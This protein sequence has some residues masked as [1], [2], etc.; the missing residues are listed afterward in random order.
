MDPDKI[1]DTM[2][3]ETQKAVEHTRQEFANIHTG[4]ASPAMV[5]NV[6]VEAY[7]SS[8]QLKAVA[9]I[10]TPDSRTISVTPFDRGTLNDVVKGIQVAN[11]G[12]NPVVMGDKVHVPLPELTKERREQL[13]K[14]CSG[15][16]EQGRVSVRAARRMA[17]DAL[18]KAEKDKAISEDDLNLYEKD[19]QS[20]TDKGIA[21]IDEALKAK[22]KDLMT[23]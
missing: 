22:E 8:M 16:A 7:G 21:D 13:V 14:T 5:E 3:A 11:I 1:L 15:H 12:L 4:K 19:V 10:T 23:V 9:A 2:K 17:M 6:N 20:E 18:K